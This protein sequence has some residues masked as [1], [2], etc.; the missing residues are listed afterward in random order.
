VRERERAETTKKLK[1]DPP[2]KKE[3]GE[4]HVGE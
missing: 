3:K 1:I 4:K 2:P